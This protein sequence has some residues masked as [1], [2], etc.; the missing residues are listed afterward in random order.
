MVE[1][2]MNRILRTLDRP[3]ID[4]LS[5]KD[6]MRRLI[7]GVVVITAGIGDER[8][9]LTA[10]SAVS[11]SMEPPTMLI[12]VNR[13][14]SSWPVIARRRHFC[15]NVLHADQADVAARFAG[16][17]GTKG[18]ARYDGADWRPMG[19]GALGL[20]GA[21]AVIDCDVE[22][23]I[24]RHSHAIVLGAVRDVQGELGDGEGLVYG[25]GRF[26]SLNLL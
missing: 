15:V 3:Y 22:E 24:E 14:S 20:V 25:H 23:T 9:G 19:S 13:S 8:T 21:L 7:G 1:Q 5:L 4:A 26:G 11:L 2:A 12:T 6:A 17:D 10:T 18:V 16:V